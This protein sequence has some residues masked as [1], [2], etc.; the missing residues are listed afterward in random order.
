MLFSGILVQYSILFLRV[1]Y[2]YDAL[3][4]I[5]SLKMEMNSYNKQGALCTNIY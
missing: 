2:F 1:A 5:N 3:A 4:N